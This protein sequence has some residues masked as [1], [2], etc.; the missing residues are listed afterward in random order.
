LTTENQT[1]R[2]TLAAAV[3]AR[4]LLKVEDFNHGII[5]LPIP[6]VPA[7]L[8]EPRKEW[9]ITAL[10]EELAEFRD[11]CDQG[12]VLEA[13]DAL[14]DLV[15][16]ALGRLVEMGV[17]AMVVFNEV[18]QANMSKLRGELSKRPNSKGYDAIKPAG[19]KAPDHS[20]LL[21]FSADD[22]KKAELWDKMSPVLKKVVE[23]RIKKGNDYNS[24]PQLKDYFPFG[25]ESYAQMVHLKS[26]RM[27][28][29]IA[30]LN[31][32]K[33][34][35]YDGILDTLEDLINYATFYAEALQSGQLE[36]PLSGAA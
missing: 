1:P 23:L 10:N 15:Y 27:L 34:L 4:M 28:S 21:S 11:A 2:E 30:V 36:L 8:S 5:G 26:T 6:H 7:V 16:F 24:G 19:W 13:A 12:D 14:V 22:V 9:A 31:A 17:P 33:A 29:Q 3:V 20:R 32:G 25:H 18:Q 35:N